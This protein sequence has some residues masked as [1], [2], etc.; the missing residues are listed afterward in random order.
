MA[1][2]AQR[3]EIDPRLRVFEEIIPARGRLAFKLYAGQVLRIVDIEGKQVADLVCFDADDH[4][5]KLSVNNTGL[6]N[7]TIFITTGH[8]LYSTKA[9]KLMT[10][11]DD[12]VG[13][14]DLIAGSCSEGTNRVRYGV[15][16]TPNCRSNF[17][18]A[19][20]SHGIPLREVPYS[21]NVFMNV[22]VTREKTE[23]I[24]PTSKPGDYIDLRAERDLLVAI[25][26]C[27]QERN[28]CNGFNPTPLKVIVY[29]VS[30]T[31]KQ[32]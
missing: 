31:G 19:L 28:P 6:M 32:L 21:F 30:P 18:Q 25:S 3:T 22:P 4:E 26:N 10:I 16:G 8:S 23:I 13:V 14:H 12:T 17:E 11:I 20:G 5:D 7:K 15:R 24:E 1:T 27:P 29:E 9:T 2:T